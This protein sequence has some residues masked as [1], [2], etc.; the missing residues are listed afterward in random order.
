MNCCCSC[1]AQRLNEFLLD[2]LKPELS[3]PMN[4]YVCKYIK[5]KE[6]KKEK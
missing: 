5:E 1:N 6:K 2:G 3:L 4:A